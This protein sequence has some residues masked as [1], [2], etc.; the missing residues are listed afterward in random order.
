MRRVLGLFERGGCP[1]ILSSQIFTLHPPW[2]TLEIL[3][4]M[5][6]IV[7]LQ[8]S[9]ILVQGLWGI[10]WYKSFCLDVE[11]YFDSSTCFHQVWYPIIRCHTIFPP[12]A[13]L[14][15]VGMQIGN[16][17]FAWFCVTCLHLTKL[18]FFFSFFP[19]CHKK[20]LKIASVLCWML[21]G[22]WRGKSGTKARKIEQI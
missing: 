11:R 19:P 2:G 16:P 10:V 13:V 20:C 6:G 22:A 12:K 14:N 9:H 4:M 21:M 15:I 1:I 18:N 5:K 3:W 8:R 17:S 7:F